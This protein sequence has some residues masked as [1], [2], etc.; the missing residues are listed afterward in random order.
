M[1]DMIDLVPALKREVAEPGMFATY[2]PGV[3]NQDLT[4]WLSDA[5]GQAQLEGYLTTYVLDADVASPATSSVSPDLSPGAQ[6]LVVLYAAERILTNR[7]L[8]MRAALRTA[9]GPVKYEIENAQR[10]MQEVLKQLKDRRDRIT[11]AATGV[12][13]SHT[14]VY[15]RDQYAERVLYPYDIL[16]ESWGYSYL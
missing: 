9:A 12:G 11:I 16:A 8:N 7:I 6:A 4:P 14:G 15:T 3:S 2:F 5:M 10:V 13:G 1:T